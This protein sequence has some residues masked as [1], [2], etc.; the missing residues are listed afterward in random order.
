MSEA[1]LS[2]TGTI[3]DITGASIFS[4]LPSLLSARTTREDVLRCCRARLRGCVGAI[5]SSLN[6][7]LQVRKIARSNTK[8]SV[9]LY[10]VSNNTLRLV[11]IWAH[12]HSGLAALPSTR[13]GLTAAAAVVVVIPANR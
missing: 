5:N 4:L 10:P 6:T 2:T 11:T 7:A 12:A 1:K 9:R 8:P 13:G 3:T